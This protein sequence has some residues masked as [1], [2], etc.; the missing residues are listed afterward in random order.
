MKAGRA[1]RAFALGLFPFVLLATLNSA[2][3]RFGASD[4]AFYIPAVL[5][6]LDPSLSQLADEIVAGIVRVSGLG[7]PAVAGALYVVSLT[8]FAFAASLI[9]SLLYRSPW[10]IAALLAALTLRHAVPDSGTNTLESYFHPRQLAFALGA[11][12]VAA[13]MRR[14]L[15]AAAVLL[16]PMAALHPTTATWFAIWLG[17]AAFV[18]EPRIRPALIAVAVAGVA[19]A[20]WLLAAGPLAQ[21]LAV[22]DPEWLATLTQKEYLFPGRWSWDAWVVNMAYAPI[23][24]W[25]YGLR[26]RAGLATD[27]ELGLVLGCLALVAVFVAALPLNA[28][29][30]ALAVQLQTGRIFWMLDFLAV[31]YVVWAIAEGGPAAAVRRAQWTVAALVL[32]S[33]LRGAYSTFVMFPD[34]PVAQLTIPDNDWGRTMAW[35]RQ[36]ERDSAWLAGPIHAAMYGSSVRLAGHR[37][38]FVE[39]LKDVALGIYDR[40]VAM[41]TRERVEALGVFEEMTPERARALAARYDLDYL[42][43]EQALDL[44]LAFQ[45]GVL[46]VYRLRTP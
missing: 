6:Q 8:L 33:T 45:S 7:V 12:A 40:D 1:P 2:G 9:G 29:R 13:L 34:R 30:V 14:R 41:R 3:Y 5:L 31:T 17:V 27:V 44:P 11:L 10:T 22:M 39:P 15:A 28:A 36:S 23:I 25:V 16:V 46:R 43:T 38:V 19:A 20:V 18:A 26:R 24:L 21:R 37:D 32:A 4:Q 42:V 35:A